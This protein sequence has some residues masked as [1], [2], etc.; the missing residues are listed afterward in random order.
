MPRL[1]AAIVII[2][3]LVALTVFAFRAISRMLRGRS[4]T[5]GKVLTAVII[6][7]AAYALF[8][9]GFLFDRAVSGDRAAELLGGSFATDE[10]DPSDDLVLDSLWTATSAG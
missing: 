4:E 3:V 1:I 7:A 8:G 9:Q 6:A 5:V 10:G 2:I